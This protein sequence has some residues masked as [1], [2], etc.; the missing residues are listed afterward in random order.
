VGLRA[1]SCSTGTAEKGTGCDTLGI[2]YGGMFTPD[3]TSLGI[4]LIMST[5]SFLLPVT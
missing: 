2:E 4:T 5:S 3:F 1:D